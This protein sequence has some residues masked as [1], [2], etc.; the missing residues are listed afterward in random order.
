MEETSVTQVQAGSNTFLDDHRIQKNTK[1]NYKRKMN[2]IKIFMVA[3][4]NDVIDENGDIIVPLSRLIV[5]ELFEWLA[6]NVDIPKRS[7]RKRIGAGSR[8]NQSR[9]AG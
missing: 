2:G 7:G 1:E 6:T 5:E 8:G 3:K 4:H 9:A